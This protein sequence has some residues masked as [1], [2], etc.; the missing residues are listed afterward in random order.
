MNVRLKVCGITNI[1]DAISCANCGVNGLGFI[2][3]KS[4]RQITPKDAGAIIKQI[5]ESI[6]KVGV[7]QNQPVSYVA[8]IARISGIN[9]I[10]LHGNE[11]IEYIKKLK[12]LTKD[13]Y[14]IIKVIPVDDSSSIMLNEDSLK[15]WNRWPVSFFLLDTKIKDQCGGLGRTFPWEFAA[16]F[17]ESVKTPYF[18]AGGIGPDNIKDALNL[19]SPWAVDVNSGVENAPGIKDIKKVENTIRIIKERDNNAAT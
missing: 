18:L 10:Q 17:G 4:K 14:Q 16:R 19:L 13:S 11:D 3:C 15:A 8:E 12:K 1:K 9:F 7:F 2:F 5:D 6:F